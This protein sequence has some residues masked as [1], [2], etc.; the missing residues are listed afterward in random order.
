MNISWDRTAVSPSIRGRIRTT[1]GWRLD[2][3]WSKNLHDF[4]LWFVWAG[5]GHMAIDG[6]DLP[7][8]PGV[9]LWMRP[10]QTYLATHD[11]RRPLG[12][13][14]IHFNL[15]PS[16]DALPPTILR[17]PDVAYVDLLMQ[18]VIALP[19]TAQHPNLPAELLRPLL[20]D[21][22]RHNHHP[23]AAPLTPTL[24]HQRRA[25]DALIA[26]VHDNPSRVPPLASLARRFG[27]TPEHFGRV[28]RKHTGLCPNEFRL[29]YRINRATQLLLESSLTI[30]QI[31]LTLG[32]AQEFF[33]S[34][35]F[36]HKT[37]RSPTEF[38]RRGG[39]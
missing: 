8:R 17:L 16:P 27:W 20:I 15:S 18:R 2:E 29:R 26:L 25:V 5:R 10:G 35:Q 39:L 4:D 22:D 9:C 31:A 33:F 19:D 12:V 36:K 7:L 3:R 23:P 32:Y 11:S 34:R 28:F 21:L 6:R 38:R 37:G 24:E 30:K 13:N 1:P 14:F